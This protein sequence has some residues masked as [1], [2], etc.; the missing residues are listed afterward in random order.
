MKIDNA[1][2]SRRIGMLIEAAETRNN[3]THPA[4]SEYLTI[5]GGTLAN[6]ISAKTLHKMRATDLV[7]LEKLSGEKL[8]TDGLERR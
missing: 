7:M 8:D 2:L 1:K 5:K 3:M 4:L 6:M